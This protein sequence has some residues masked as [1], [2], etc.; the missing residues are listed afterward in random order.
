MKLRR[1][2][3][4]IKC[5]SCCCYWCCC[6]FSVCFDSSPLIEPSFN[7]FIITTTYIFIYRY[8]IHLKNNNKQISNAPF[9]DY[10]ITLVN[11]AV[12]LLFKSTKSTCTHQKQERKNNHFI[13]SMWRGCWF[14]YQTSNVG[15]KTNEPTNKKWTG[16]DKCPLNIYRVCS[17]VYTFLFVLFASV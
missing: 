15:A 16:L 9:G 10:W 1:H 13:L 5:C 11:L 7:W 6:Y 12:G 14:V 17:Y 2:W 8:R 4:P 3:R